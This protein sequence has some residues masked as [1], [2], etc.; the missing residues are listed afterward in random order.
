MQVQIVSDLHLELD[1]PRKGA[2]QYELPVKA[3]NLVL[4]GNTG[5]TVDE[6]LFVWLKAQL[7]KFRLI[8]YVSG[9]KEQWGSSVIESTE[10][11]RAFARY[12]NQDDA[13]GTFVYL[14]R[15]RYD[16]DHTLTILGCTLWSQ[17]RRGTPT[18]GQYVGT[19]FN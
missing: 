11:L 3:P 19:S 12:V 1:R 13:S 8:F 16:V 5:C 9:N 18:R 2:Y 15:N 17:S 7:T 4:I 10:R 6:K 14:N